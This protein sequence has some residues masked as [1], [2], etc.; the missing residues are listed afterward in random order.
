MERLPDGLIQFTVEQQTPG[1]LL[2]CPVFARDVL[3]QLKIYG[4]V[5]RQQEKVDKRPAVRE[6]LPEMVKRCPISAPSPGNKDIIALV[7]LIKPPV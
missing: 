1:R 7:G 5:Y 4:L 6:R 3:N 2:N